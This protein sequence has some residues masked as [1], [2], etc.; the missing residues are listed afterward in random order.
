MIGHM[1][2]DCWVVTGGAGYIGSHVLDLLLESEKDVLVYDSLISGLESRVKYLEKKHQ[3]KIPFIKGDIRDCAAIDR[4]FGEYK[5]TG[6]VHTAALKSVRESFIKR[7][8]YFEVNTSS[9]GHLARLMINHEIRNLVFSSTAAVYGRP[10]G[11]HYVKETDST[12]PISPYGQ[13][14]LEAEGIVT[15]FLSQEGNQGMSLRFFNVV[16]AESLDLLDNSKENLIPI[17]LDDIAK[18][19]VPTIYGCDYPTKDGT[20]VRDYIDVR[21]VA[22]AHL[23]SIDFDGSIPRIMNIGT[24]VGTTVR[25]VIELVYSLA[26]QIA[27]HPR[28]S[29]RRVGDPAVL[30][31]DVSLITK[32]IG[33]KTEYDIRESI[34][35]MLNFN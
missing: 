33:F 20:C 7:N 12:N 34:L 22:R 21:D 13:S 17:L 32:N 27:P 26:K 30:C 9:T 10:S 25:E 14:K 24:G 18:N 35:S 3:T 16:G 11:S 4:V 23:A 2:K 15:N 19:R 8:E 1:K 5:P 6:V 28:L 29:D 31:A